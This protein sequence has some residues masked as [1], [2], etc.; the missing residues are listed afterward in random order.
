MPSYSVRVRLRQKDGFARR[1]TT[2]F[3]Y[4]GLHGEESFQLHFF[5]SETVFFS[6]LGFQLVE[7]LQLFFTVH[8]QHLVLVAQ[9]HPYISVVFFQF[10]LPWEELVVLPLRSRRLDSEPVLLV[11]LQPYDIHV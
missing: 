6:K 8:R 2:S 10:I 5:K 9:Y 7:F 1:S 3:R 4:L 11:S